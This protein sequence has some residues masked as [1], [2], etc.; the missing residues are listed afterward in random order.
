MAQE[1][2]Q[3]VAAEL[4]VGIVKLKPMVQADGNQLTAE[5]TRNAKAVIIAAC[6]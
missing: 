1:A 4:G 5:D 6:R 3:K 2:L